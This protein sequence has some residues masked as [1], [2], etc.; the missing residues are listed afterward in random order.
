MPELVP[1][2]IHLRFAEETRITLRRMRI[3][4]KALSRIIEQQPENYD[5]KLAWRA[6]AK[7]VRSLKCTLKTEKR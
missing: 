5:A 2:N 1:V 4:G 6:F 3:A 7:L